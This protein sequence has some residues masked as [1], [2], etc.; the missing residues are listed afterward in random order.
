MN[1]VYLILVH[2]DPAQLFRLIEVLNDKQVAF[3]IHVDKQVSINQ[4]KVYNEKTY[5]NVHF[6]SNRCVSSWGSFGLVQA[7]LN[8]LKFIE[9]NHKTTQRIILLSGQD[10]PIK[11]NVYIKAY[12]KSHINTIFIEHFKI[13]YKKWYRN[14]LPRF[15]AFEEINQV[16]NI[17]GG[18]QWLSLPMYAIKIIFDFLKLNPDFLTYFKNYVRI[19]DESFFQTLLLNCDNPK[20]TDNIIN[21]NL[22]LIKWN[23][24]Y[25]NPRVLTTESKNIVNKSK[26]LFTRKLDPITSSE[27]ICHIDEKILDREVN[28]N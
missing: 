1:I 6:I 3:V 18:S 11:S 17:Y 22:H 16:M 15:P 2:K 7:T 13:P 9:R 4:F 23:K 26:S 14:G 5:Q 28:Q 10:Y 24:P 19:P 20:I 21:H 8:G 12:L 25:L 27:L